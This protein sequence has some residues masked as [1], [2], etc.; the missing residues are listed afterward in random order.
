MA[1]SYNHI[2]DEKG[3]LVTNKDF[4]DFIGNLGDAYEMAEECWYLIQILS[5]GDKEKI[6]KAKNTTIQILNHKHRK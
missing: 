6:E 3:D 5:G 4:I 1:G 2:T